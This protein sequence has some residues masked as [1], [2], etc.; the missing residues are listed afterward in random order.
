VGETFGADGRGRGKI[1]GD[2]EYRF[3]PAWGRKGRKQQKNEQF[4]A[5]VQ[6]GIGFVLP[7]GMRSGIIIMTVMCAG[8]AGCATTMPST[9]V[10][11]PVQTQTAA[12]DPA[13]RQYDETCACALVFDPPVTAALP[14][15]DLAR[16]LRQPAAFVGWESQ[17]AT[18]LDVLTSD[19][20]A[21]DGTTTFSRDATIEKVGVTYR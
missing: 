10:Q 20:W 15:I 4:G 16:G 9:A 8:L 1:R 3:A 21:T 13:A 18:Y 19:H 7:L 6:G 17:S 2:A 5:C 11:S 12:V 14:P